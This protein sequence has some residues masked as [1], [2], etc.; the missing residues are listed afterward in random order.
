MKNRRKQNL[1]GE[2]NNMQLDKE[3]TRVNATKE[4]LVSL[5]MFLK[6]V[7]N[8]SLSSEICSTREAPTKL[9]VLY[10]S[11]LGETGLKNSRKISRFFR[12]IVPENPA[13][14]D[15]FRNL[16]EALLT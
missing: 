2:A 15:F 5:K 4:H 16:P 12:K 8:Q 10:Q 7:Q 6:S 1:K 11:F 14:F 13:K 9:A 3:D